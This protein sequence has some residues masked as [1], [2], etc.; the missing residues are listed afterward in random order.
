MPCTCV[1][2]KASFSP[3]ELSTSQRYTTILLQAYNFRLTA[4]LPTPGSSYGGWE[5]AN[6]E[7]RGQFMGHYLTAMA[8]AYQNTGGRAC[9]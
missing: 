6:V 3:W 1:T 9:Q 7:V 4:G 2:V 8:Y 5:D